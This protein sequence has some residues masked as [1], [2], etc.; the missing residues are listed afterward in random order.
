M[1]PINLPKKSNIKGFWKLNE[2]SG[3][4]YDETTNNNNLTDNATVLYAAGKIGNAADFELA[5][6]EYL[7]ITDA[8]QTG[9]DITGEITICAW[10]KLE[11]TGIAQAVACKFSSADNK[12]AY[13]LYIPSG[14]TLNFYLSPDGTTTGAVIATSTDTLSAATW[15]HVACT[16]NQTTDKVQTYINGLANGSA[17]NYTTNIYDN[18]KKF[19]IGAC[20]ESTGVTTFFDGLIDEA[21]VWNKCLTAA[22]VLQVKNISNYSYGRFMPF[23]MSMRKAY[24]RHDKLWT[25]KGLILP[26]DLGFQI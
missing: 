4:R 11:S 19:I 21:I 22:E 13:L 8:A 26:K 7:S 23:F 14:N 15:Y 16:L 5:T 3:T 17:F 20:D 12:R 10:V 25:P 6:S 1:I 9:L 18:A 24:E 2:L